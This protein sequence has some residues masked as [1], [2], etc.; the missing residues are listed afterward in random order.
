[1]KFGFLHLAESRQDG[2]AGK[3]SHEK[4]LSGVNFALKLYL[5]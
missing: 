3:L 4:Y 5:T 1:V 2:I